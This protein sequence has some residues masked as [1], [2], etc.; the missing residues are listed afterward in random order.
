MKPILVYFLILFS[1][2]ASAQTDNYQFQLSFIKLFKYPATFRNACNPTFANIM[3]D[4][5]ANGDITGISVSDSAP[6]FFKNEFNL[7]KDTLNKA[8]INNLIAEK[9]LKNCSILIPVFYVYESGWCA[10]SF[11][12]FRPYNYLTFNGKEIDHLTYNLKPIFVN[13]YKPLH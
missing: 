2:N 3:I 8:P 11:D 5:S 9:G 6:F 4:V 7:I 1:F 10:N 13:M 12:E